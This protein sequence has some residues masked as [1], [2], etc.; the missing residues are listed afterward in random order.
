M[1]KVE[2]AKAIEIFGCGFAL[3]FGQTEMSPLSALFRP[4]HQ[5]NHTG[6]AG[7]PSINVQIAI[8]DEAGNFLPEGE[9]GEIVY[10]S[11]QVMTG[12]LHNPDATQEAFRHGWFHSGDVGRF[13]A[14]GILWFED[15]FKDV[16]K[17]GGENVAS[18]EVESAVYASEP[19]ILEA[20]IVGL[21][22]ERWGE[23]ITAFIIPRAGQT[24]DEAELLAKVRERLSPFKCPKAVIVVEAFPK[25]ATGKVQKVEL[26]KIFAEYY[27]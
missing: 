17:S 14:D 13:D 12:Y 21:P 8:M 1:A 20:A 4:E 15:R 10:R 9:A 25:T 23:A 5:L 18:I 2:L 3:M 24:I 16:I 11:P 22:H 27:K 19:A 7:T 26:R 6:A